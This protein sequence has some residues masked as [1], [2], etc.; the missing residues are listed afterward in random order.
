MENTSTASR[1]TAKE[2]RSLAEI[3]SA[4]TLRGFHRHLHN[5]D[6]HPVVIAPSFMTSDVATSMMRR[7][8]RQ[9]GFDA[10][11][12][13]QGLNTGLREQVYLAFERHVKDLASRHCRKVSVVGWSLG[14]IYARSLA[15]RQ[16]D[17]IRQVI[18]L[19]SPINI[20]EMRGVSGPVLKLY[21][22]LNPGAMDDPMLGWREEWCS[23][24]P[25]PS[26][27][28]YSAS[29]G[30]VDWQYCIHQQQGAQSENLRV[31]A[32]HM[33]MTHNLAVLYALSDRLAQREGQWKPFELT[34]LRRR[35]FDVSDHLV[36]A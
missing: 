29:D 11:G 18:T 10:Y 22:A 31:P 20:P 24:P 26:T 13:E 33:G 14:G 34:G 4:F 8:L 1:S 35:L 17:Y 2:L 16:P 3:F 32:S 21:E 27:A 30:I 15:Q 19:G 7:A 5:G 28:M 25:V 6:G 12:W 23:A 9:T 36:A